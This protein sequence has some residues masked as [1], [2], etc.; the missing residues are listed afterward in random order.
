MRTSYSQVSIRRWSSKSK[1]PPNITHTKAIHVYDFDNTLFCSPLPNPQIWSPPAVGMLQAYETLAYGGWWHDSS[2][3]AATG[4]GIE[5][6]EP[7]AWEGW[8][9]DTVVQLVEMSILSKDVLTVLLTGRG[10]TDFADLVNR[11]CN[12]KN[13]DFDLVV[14]KPEVGPSGQRFESTMIFKQDFLKELVFTYKNADEIRIYEDRTK[15][16]K[17]F[18]EYFERLNKSLISHPVDQPPPPR[19]PITAEVIHVCELKSALNPDTEIEVVQR[20]INRHNHAVLTGGPNPTKSVRKQLK[21]VEHFSYFGYLINQTDSARLITLCSIPPH[22]IDSGEVRLLASS[23]LITPYYPRRDTVKQAG[24]RG[25]KVTWQVTGIAKFEDRIWAAKVAPVS[26]TQI[27]TQDPIPLV[28]LA[29]R[30]GSR[31][32]DASRIHEWQPVAPEKAFMF[33][34]TVGDKIMLKIEEQDFV[35]GTGSK[36]VR[37]ARTVFDSSDGGNKRKYPQDESDFRGKESYTR[38]T[39]G[40]DRDDG[41]WAAKDRS[42]GGGGKFSQRNHASKT[43]FNN[44]NNPNMPGARGNIQAANASARQRNAGPGAGGN[45]GRAG[46]G[47]GGGG[48]RG[49]PGYKS[50]DDYGP[51]NFDGA[52]DMKT[53][54]GEMVMNY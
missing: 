24:G 46:G 41:T 48:N 33:E 22:L 17:G 32:V 53:G 26:E 40:G 37:K 15:H 38:V 28:V 43:Q 13:L 18:R 6:E 34:T 23:I 44:R 54:S 12:A 25:K 42:G 27:Y 5:K 19:K 2:I 30:K 47:P 31:Q 36:G 7:R 39:A 49:P 1:D 45:R 4:D 8:W 10:E 52:N 20:A 51:G 50:L 21:I 35:V 3:L 16:V 29:I 9:N 11:I 14:L